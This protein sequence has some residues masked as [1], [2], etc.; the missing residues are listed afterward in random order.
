MKQHNINAV[1]TS[2]Y[3]NDPRFYELADRYGLY[4]VDEADNESHVTRIDADGRPDIPGDRPELTANVV[5]RMRNMVERD[6]NH[7]SVV[8]WSTRQRVGRRGEP[9]GDVRLDE[10]QR[11]DTAGPLPGRDRIGDRRRARDHLGLRRRLLPAHRRHP[12][13]G[14]ARPS[15]LRHDGVR[16]QPGQHVRVPGGVLVD[17]P[18]AP[19]ASSRAASSGTGRT[20]DCGGRC[21]AGKAR[22]SSPTAETGATTPTK[23]ART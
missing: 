2:H 4:V 3:P 7:P 19:R 22:S 11:P 14:P 12:R 23:A 15:A 1:R 9:A 16:L 18:R 6:K 8:A 21:L 5:W 20:R 10:G 17:H 13:A